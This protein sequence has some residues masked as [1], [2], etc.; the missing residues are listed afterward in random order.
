M[1]TMTPDTDAPNFHVGAGSRILLALAGLMVPA[2]AGLYV[3]GQIP[4]GV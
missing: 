4:P 3:Y 2:A 1:S